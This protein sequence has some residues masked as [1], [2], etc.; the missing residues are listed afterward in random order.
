[1]RRQVY[2]DNNNSPRESGGCFIEGW[3]GARPSTPRS[4]VETVLHAGVFQRPLPQRLFDLRRH[5][6]SSA[7]SAG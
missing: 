5:A 4:T 1:V 6:G 2:G 7:V 3:C